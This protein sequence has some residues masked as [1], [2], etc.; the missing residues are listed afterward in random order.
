M[1]RGFRLG[2]KKDEDDED[3]DEPNSKKKTQKELEELYM[4]GD[5]EGE[6]SFSRMMSHLLILVTFSSGM[7]NLYFVGFLFF[8]FTFLVEKWNLILIFKK[9]TTLN[10]II[11]LYSSSLFNFA[12]L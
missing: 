9:T 8:T 3:D 2:L 6:G 5:Y 10:R 11:P 4:G 1:D 7:P 12:I